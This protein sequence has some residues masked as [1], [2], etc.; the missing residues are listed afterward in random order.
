MAR[1]ARRLT[2]FALPKEE[3]LNRLLVP[4]V[5]DLVLFYLLVNGVADP[6]GARLFL[7]PLSPFLG[8]FTFVGEGALYERVWGGYAGHVS[9][10][11]YPEGKKGDATLFGQPTEPP[12]VD[13]PKRGLAW[14]IS[15]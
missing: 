3:N 12:D 15:Q 9:S 4:P 1:D 14:A 6:F 11:W 8:G 2:A 10:W 7:F 5:G 13:E